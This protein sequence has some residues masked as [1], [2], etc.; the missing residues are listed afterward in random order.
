[1]V[2]A[3]G[4]FAFDFAVTHREWSPGPVALG[5]LLLAGWYWL[6]N[7]GF[8]YGRPLLKFFALAIGL[9]FGG[10]LTAVCLDRAPAQLAATSDGMAR[11]ETAGALYWA[12]FVTAASTLTIAIHAL[13]V[14]TGRPSI[15]EV[16]ASDDPPTHTDQTPADG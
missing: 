4:G 3:A 14:G 11:R 2:F 6:Y 12:G 9:A 13:V 8:R 7:I 10:V 1:M 5:W 16:E 15:E